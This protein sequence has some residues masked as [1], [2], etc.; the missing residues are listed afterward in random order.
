MANGEV[1]GRLSGALAGGGRSQGVGFCLPTGR[2]VDQESGL[3]RTCALLRPLTARVET[4]S[5]D[6]QRNLGFKLVRYPLHLEQ[7]FI[8]WSG[9]GWEVREVVGLATDVFGHVRAAGNQTI[10]E[11]EPL[12]VIAAGCCDSVVIP[13]LELHPVAQHLHG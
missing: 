6:R 9:F 7:C 4:R 5:C 11:D 8:P 10:I 13:G 1:D 12:C 3:T 2:I